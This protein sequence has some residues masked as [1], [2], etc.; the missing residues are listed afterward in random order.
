MVQEAAPVLQTDASRIRFLLEADAEL[1]AFF[2]DE[3]L[4]AEGREAA[5]QTFDSH[6]LAQDR[7]KYVT[8]YIGSKQ[9]LIDWIWA[10]TPEDMT[11]AVD[12]FSGSS[13]VGYMYKSKGLGVDA[14]DRLAYCHHIARAI[15]EN[16]G[17]TLSDEEIDAL[18]AAN[19]KASDFVRKQF[20]GI[21]FEPGVHAVIDTIRSNIDQQKLSGFKLDIA[22]FALGKACITGK[23]GF[24]HFGTTQKQEGRADSPAEFRDRFAANCKRINELVF[25]GERPCKAHHGDSRKVLSGVKADVAYFDPPYACYRATPMSP[26]PHSPR[27]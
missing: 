13:V 14:T 8:N 6:A 27:T 22:L 25:K 20:K 10:S 16:D 15:V 2:A 21:Y 5:E 23:G 24:G 19:A 11:T 1:A 17:V 12:A 9:K 18:L 26:P 4:E 3:S 7:P